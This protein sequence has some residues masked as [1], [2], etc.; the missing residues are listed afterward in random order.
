MLQFT[1]SLCHNVVSGCLVTRDSSP[2][3]LP[4]PGTHRPLWDVKSGGTT[5]AVCLVDQYAWREPLILQ[6]QEVSHLVE[7]S[8]PVSLEKQNPLTRKDPWNLPWTPPLQSEGPWRLQTH[9][10]MSPIFPL[11][12]NSQGFFYGGWQPIPN[13]I[14]NCESPPRPRPPGQWNCERDAATLSLPQFTTCMG[15]P[16]SG[17]AMRGGRATRQQG[18]LTQQ[19]LGDQH[20]PSLMSQ[21]SDFTEMPT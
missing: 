17:P 8:S 10:V 3:P 12:P 5:E 1:D 4:K 2:T 15:R 20:L 16:S 9:L 21:N 19:L 6:Q 11:Q 7:E 13:N 14:P 18:S